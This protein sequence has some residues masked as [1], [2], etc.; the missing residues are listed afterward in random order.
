MPKN[1]DFWN[2][3]RWVKVGDSEIQH[4]VPHYHHRLDGMSGTL[5]CELEALTPLI[6]GDGAGKEGR[7]VNFVRHAK[8]R[9]PYIPATSLKGAVRSLA[10]LVGNAAVPIAK[11]Q[12]DDQHQASQ[13]ALGTGTHRQLDIAARM[14]GFLQGGEVFTGLVYV[15]DA[16]ATERHNP[17]VW[18]TFQ[19]AGGQPDPG[20]RPFYP[21]RNQ[22]KFYHHQ[23]KTEVLTP[24]PAGIPVNQRRTIRPAPPGTRFDFQTR[25]VNLREEEL[26]LLLYCLVLEEQVHVTLSK[27]ALGPGYTAPLIL[28]GPLRHKMGGCKPH[29]AGSVRIDVR[30]LS[31]QT[32]PAARYRGGSGPQVLEGQ[33]LQDEL[34]RRTQAFRERNDETMQQLRAMLIYADN[35]PRGKHVHYPSYQWFQQDR[36]TTCKAP[37][38][39]TV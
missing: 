11:S 7:E 17:A 8:E 31:L 23:P 25:F 32:D 37:L 10:E 39:P 1:N 27:E 9:T 29:G 13:A 21:D 3:Y 18:P 36:D 33:A 34:Y 2:P 12:V 14:F 24:P 20:H 4:A 38:K 19:V 28:A 6:I 16:E 30:R 15:S 35:D 22:R 5:W 26:N